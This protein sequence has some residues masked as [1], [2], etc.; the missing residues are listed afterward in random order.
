MDAIRLS[1]CIPVYNFGAFIGATLDTIVRQLPENVEIV[2]LDGA[3]TDATPEIVAGYQARFPRIRYERADRRGGIDRDI[4]K[5]VA[6]AR[7]DYCWLFSGDDLMREGAVDRVLRELDS[8]CDVY[9]LE[10]MLCRFDMTPMRVHRL[11]A[12]S[13]PRTFQL[14]D[15]AERLEYCRLALNTAAFFSYCSSLVFS[16]SRWDA[17]EVD[18]SFYGSHFCP[19]ARILAML[20]RGLTVRYLPGP[21]LDNRA[22][23]DSFNTKGMTH[24]YGIAID[25]YHRIA[26]WYFG[27]DSREA[28][29]IRR[30]IRPEQPWYGWLSA[31][32][33]AARS[34]DKEQIALFNHLLR[35]QYSDPS[36]ATWAAHAVCRYSP[37]SVLI[38]ARAGVYAARRVVNRVLGR[39]PAPPSEVVAA[40]RDPA[41]A[42]RSAGTGSR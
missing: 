37:A 27:H 10:A 34:G 2:I 36:V 24:R 23:V 32:V 11:L 16:R 4:A 41:S 18:E 33:D 31:K 28:Y 8:G 5:A 29:H 3:S 39:T 15:P 26:D 17:T 6:L 25:S 30:S 9:L 7:G 14:D 35:K 42:R 22:G 38:A 13:S 21:F 12:I 40:V 19:A 1:V 20:P